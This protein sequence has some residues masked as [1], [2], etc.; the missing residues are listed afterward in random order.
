MKTLR[1]HPVCPAC[2]K[3]FR[4]QVNL[5]YISNQI[6]NQSVTTGITISILKLSSKSEL[7]SKSSSVSIALF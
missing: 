6:S 4:L 7:S 3:L 1:V 2:R 5:V